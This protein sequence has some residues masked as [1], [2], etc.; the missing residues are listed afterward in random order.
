[1]NTVRRIANNTAVLLISQAIGKVLHFILAIFVARYLGVALFGKY[2]FAISFTLLFSVLADMGLNILIVREVSRDRSK[3]STYLGIT[4]IIKSILALIAFII[5]IVIINLMHYPSETITAVYI[6]AFALAFNT[7]TSTLT[8]V[9]QAFERMEYA[10]IVN[11]LVAALRLGLTVL[12]I[13]YRYGLYEIMTVY[14]LQSI[15]NLTINAFIVPKKFVK[16]KFT[17]DTK[18]GFNLLKAAIPVGLAGIFVTIY[19]RID[20]VMLSFMKGDAVVGWYNAAYNLIFGL[21]FIQSSFNLA[22][23][24][25]LSRLFNSSMNSFRRVYER[26]FKY[27]FYTG[28]PIAVGVTLLAERII[29]LIYGQEYLNAT[30]ALQILIWALAFIFVNGLLGNTLV[31]T[32][33]QKRA[34]CIIGGAAILNVILNVLMIPSLSYKGAAIA[35]VASEMFVFLFCS[36]ALSKSVA[37]S[38]LFKIYQKPLLA[39]LIMG[40]FIVVFNSLPILVLIPLAAIIYM[41]TLF[42]VQAFDR[43]DR[44]LVRQIFR[45]ETPGLNGDHV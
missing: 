31:A 44:N 13:F 19:Y 41:S 40:V 25:I 5:I 20:T 27:L 6:A 36:I 14:L 35:T 9:Y 16:P 32:N 39:T 43:E 3:A 15:V 2:A 22:I 21:M 45:K 1:M 8:T 26:A 37:P 17:L 42:V 10:A 24:P 34:T 28:L 7:I 38:P 11:V 33:Q 30:G 29:L 12:V 23:F 4:L 18:L